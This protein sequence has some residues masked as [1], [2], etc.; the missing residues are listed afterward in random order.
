MQNLHVI[1][2]VDRAGLVGEDGETHHGIYD[3]GFLRHAPGLTVLAPASCRELEDMLRWAVTEQ[4]GPVAIRYPRG[5]D[6]GYTD[7]SW[8]TKA[9][10][11][12]TGAFARHRAG[13][14]VTLVTYGTML[15]NVMAAADLLAEQGIEAEVLRL[16]T[17]SALPADKISAGLPRNGRVVIAEE[18]SGHCGIA[19]E[20]AYE[21]QKRRPDCLVR[22]IDLGNRYIPHGSL[23]ALYDD[24]G[25]SPKKI[26]SFV[27]E[28]CSGEN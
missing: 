24:C 3:V 17:L 23:N 8:T 2:A 27:A 22:S 21:L 12:K 5:G 16:L 6:R 14:D 7:S 10:I 25:L 15:N 20:L 11:T 19:Q 28:V 9:G 26:L 13:K 18:V 1:F 4:T